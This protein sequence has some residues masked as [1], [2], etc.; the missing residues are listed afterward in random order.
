MILLGLTV[1]VRRIQVRLVGV[2]RRTAYPLPTTTALR[3][4]LSPVE[5]ALAL[6]R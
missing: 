6:G 3:D 2:R 5:A 4:M 1:C